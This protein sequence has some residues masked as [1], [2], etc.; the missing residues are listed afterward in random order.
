METIGLVTALVA[1]CHQGRRLVMPHLVAAEEGGMICRLHQSAVA[2]KGELHPDA[3]KSQ[4]N[5]S[6]PRTSGSKLHHHGR[7]PVLPLL[8]SGIALLNVIWLVNLNEDGWKRRRGPGM[9]KAGSFVDTAQAWSHYERFASIRRHV[10]SFCPSLHFLDAAVKSLPITESISDG[11]R[12]H[13]SFSNKQQR[14]TSLAS[15]VML[16]WPL[17]IAN[18]RPSW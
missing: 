5:P 4:D 7:G 1:H 2:T 9:T 18:A 12:K 13:C 10:C 17:Y 6:P 8:P 15:L 3:G 14:P 11:R 16:T